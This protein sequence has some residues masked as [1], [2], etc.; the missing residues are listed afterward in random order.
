MY[1][2]FGEDPFIRPTPVDHSPFSAWKYAEEHAPAIV[3][4]LEEKR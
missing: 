1:R 4:K 2:S 3:K